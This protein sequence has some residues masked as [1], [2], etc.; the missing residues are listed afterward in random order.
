MDFLNEPIRRMTLQ[1]YIQ[2]AT[3]L[4]VRGLNFE[5]LI[6]WNKALTDSR[7]KRNKA[8]IYGYRAVMFF[9]YCLYKQFLNNILMYEKYF[10][11]VPDMKKL[12]KRCQ[13]YMNNTRSNNI[14]YEIFK[15]S[16][17]PNPKLPFIV[18]CLKLRTKSNSKH[19]IK[20]TRHLRIG[21]VIAM[22]PAF[23]TVPYNRNEKSPFIEADTTHQRCHHCFKSN[24][25]DLIPC[26]D[27]K[28]GEFN[29]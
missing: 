23:F 7:S 20:T 25:T 13:R 5:A 12:K 10:Q 3:A 17:P 21:D 28:T 8:I 22:E 6:I 14:P 29:Y 24:Y 16:Y 2:E 27:C 4:E 9:Q 11:L 26:Y 18:D 15:L 1:D 19:Y